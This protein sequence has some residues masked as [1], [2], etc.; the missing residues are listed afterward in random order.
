MMAHWPKIAPSRHA[1]RSAICANHVVD[2]DVDADD[3]FYFFMYFSYFKSMQYCISQINEIDCR[4]GNHKNNLWNSVKLRQP[5]LKLSKVWK[6]TYIF[7]QKNIPNFLTASQKI[8]SDKTWAT[9]YVYCFH[10]ILWWREED[11]R[12]NNEWIER[13]RELLLEGNFRMLISNLN[14]EQ[15]SGGIACWIHGSF[16]DPPFAIS[17]RYEYVTRNGDFSPYGDF[18]DPECACVRRSWRR[19]KERKGVEWVNELLKERLRRLTMNKEE[20][21]KRRRIKLVA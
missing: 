7:F 21:A 16:V 3:V 20:M 11:I 18:N 8:V 9:V 14:S 4:N 2:V 12:V 10:M 1:S 17:T 5:M 6:I 13:E 19:M 15:K